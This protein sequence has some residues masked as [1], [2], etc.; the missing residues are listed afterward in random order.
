VAGARAAR[1][2]VR[3]I[4]EPA[5]AFPE[6]LGSLRDAGLRPGARVRVRRGASGVVVDTGGSEVEVP[7]GVAEHVYVAVEQPDAAVPA[8]VP[9]AATPGR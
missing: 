2:L 1:V 4:G 7:V 8:A 6:V 5:Q 3:R 9:G